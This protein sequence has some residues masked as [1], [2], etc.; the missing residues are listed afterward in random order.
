MFSLN[1][2]GSNLKRL[3]DKTGKK[4]LNGFTEIVNESNFKF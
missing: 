3:K 4:V 2:H 1:M